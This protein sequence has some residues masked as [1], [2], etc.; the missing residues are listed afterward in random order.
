MENAK[1]ILW[2]LRLIYAVVCVFGL[3]ILGRAF[4]IGVIHRDIWLEKRQHQTMNFQTIEAIRGNVYSTDGRLLATSI[5]IYDVHMDLAA[6]A[7]NKTFKKGI[8]S[9]ALQLSLLFPEKSKADFKED[10][11]RGRRAKN[12]YFL[13]RKNVNYNQLK[14][15]RSFPILRNGKYKGGMIV[16][17][18]SRREMPFRDLAFRTLGRYQEG[19]KPVGLEGHFNKYLEGVGG[20]RLVQKISGGIWKP[21]NIENEVDPTEG[22]DLITTLDVNIQ[23]VAENELKRQLKT[24]NARQ[25]CVVLMEVKTGFVRAIANLTRNEDS[26]YSE[27]LNYAVGNCTEPGST[28]KLASLMALFED[29]LASPTDIY[30]SHG[31]VVYYRGKPME[32]SHKGG[33]GK[34]SLARAFEVSSNTVV[35]QAVVGAY[36]TNQ[37]KYV[38]R[39]KKFHLD[40]PLGIDIPGEGTPVIHEPSQ[41]IW[42]GITLPWMSVGYATLLTPLQILTFYNAVANNGKM[43]KPQFVE[44]IVHRGQIVKKFEPII[45]DPAICSQATIDKVKPM[46]E[47]VVEHGTAE[48]LKNPH[49]KIAGKTGTAQIADKNSGYGVDGSRKYQASFVGYFP[50]DNPKYSCI[51]VV[52][53]PTGFAYT[54]NLVAGPVFREVANKVYAQSIDIQ[55]RSVV[56]APQTQQTARIRPGYAPDIELV[57]NNLGLKANQDGEDLWVYARSNSNI[58]TFLPLSLRSGQVPDVTGMGLRDALYLLEN[59]G[60]RVK[61]VGRGNV[62]SQSLTPGTRILPNAEVTIQLA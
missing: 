8:D 2:R 49:F 37:Q 47:G 53:A 44:E 7:L 9:L 20:K 3:L 30:D 32:D 17:Q 35:S 4:S 11:Q 55:D 34:I 25:G 29:G 12:R 39:I 52:S 54:G 61:V 31:G 48:N 19:I 58:P 16:D 28:F 41:K 6:E 18:R 62:K 42:S 43:V 57:M 5:P 56:L 22:N 38:D 36:Q 50:A 27:N 14:L 10:I 46:L 13:L 15:M 59:R 45:I 40:Q 26:T 1:D 51:V 33:Y 23:D 60:I 21:V 24:H